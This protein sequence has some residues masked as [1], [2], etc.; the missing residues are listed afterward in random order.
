MIKE[1]R[2]H[3]NLG[4]GGGRGAGAGRNGAY[5]SRLAVAPGW[6]GGIHQGCLRIKSKFQTQRGLQRNTSAIEWRRI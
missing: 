3:L 6:R 1:F 4:R 5:S 2:K